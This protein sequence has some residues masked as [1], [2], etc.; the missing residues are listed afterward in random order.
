MRYWRVRV[1]RRTCPGMSLSLVKM[2]IM[3]YCITFSF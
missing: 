2:H 3:I 1:V